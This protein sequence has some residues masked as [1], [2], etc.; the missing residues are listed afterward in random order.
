MKTKTLHHYLIVTLLA[1]AALSLSSSAGAGIVNT[2]AYLT[3]A[4]FRMCKPQT[5]EQRLLF[6]VARPYRLLRAGSP[7]EN[8]FA[9]KDEAAG[10]AYVGGEAEYLRFVELARQ[11][12]FALGGY[13][14]ADMELDPAW[15]WYIA[16]RECL[17]PRAPELSPK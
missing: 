15:R 8:F 3:N 9:Y 14:P 17:G 4:G 5:P 6:G 16:F 12:G 13:L 1:S 10:V 2:P 7:S 11:D